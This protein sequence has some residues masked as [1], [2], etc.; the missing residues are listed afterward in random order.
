MVFIG[1][2]G[3]VGTGGGLVGIGPPT[4]P[5]GAGVA[6][7]DRAAV[8]AGAAAGVVDSTAAFGL[9]GISPDHRII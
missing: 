7:D 1:P 2:V 3:M 8:A 6:D 9:A 4:S 5:A